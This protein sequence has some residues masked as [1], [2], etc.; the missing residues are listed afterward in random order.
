MYIFFIYKNNTFNFDIKKDVSILYLK[1]LASKLI[2]KDT[3]SFYLFYNNQILSEDNTSIF[4]IAKSEKNIPI[5]IAEKHKK[6]TQKLPLLKL[7]HHIDINKTESNEVKNE[8]E[9]YSDFSSKDLFNNNTKSCLRL[10]R[11][12]KIKQKNED[13]ISINK[14]FE[15]VFKAKDE[16]INNLRKNLGKKLLEYDDI[17]YKKYKNG[18]DKDNNQLLEYEKNIIDF[19]DKQIMFLKKLINYFDNADSISF[20]E[21]VID[22]DEFYLE[23]SNN[24]NNKNKIIINKNN[25]YNNKNIYQ[26]SVN[27]NISNEKKNKKIINKKSKYIALSETKI[28]SILNT[29]NKDEDLSDSDK[30]ISSDKNNDGV[31]IKKVKTVLTNQKPKKLFLQNNNSYS[32]QNLKPNNTFDKK[33]LVNDDLNI[34]KIKKKG[35]V[36]ILEKHNNEQ[37]LN[38]KSLEKN[39]I[40]K[41]K[42]KSTQ[43]LIKSRLNTEDL[44]FDKNKVNILYEISEKKQENTEDNL[45]SDS[46]SEEERSLKEKKIDY[47]YHSSKNI[48][49][50]QRSSN[51]RTNK[52]INYGHIKNP[53]IGYMMKMKERKVNQRIKKLGNNIYDFLI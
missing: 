8:S 20:H 2:N 47:I 24:N 31:L 42:K 23:I 25:N 52:T 35:M 43:F 5:I 27:N 48:Q 7:S 41:I 28:P 1:N 40:N 6:K 34:E 9:L 50:F 30:S 37:N 3:S 18:I 15:D 13:Y 33:N 26:N 38:Y 21:G 44:K 51:N 45:D 22:L 29:K 39:N 32:I 46:N 49:N 4:Q 14:V 17:L 53:R 10:K 19:K 11:E 16:E 36:N 12:L